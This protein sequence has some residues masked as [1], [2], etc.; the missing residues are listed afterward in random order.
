MYYRS[1]FMLTQG[2]IPQQER[3]SMVARIRAIIVRIGFREGLIWLL[4]WF[5]KGSMI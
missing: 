4:E 3:S 5:Y 1:L 2:S